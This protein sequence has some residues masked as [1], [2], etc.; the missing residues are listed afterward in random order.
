M[1]KQLTL[2]RIFTYL[3]M[4]VNKGFFRGATATNRA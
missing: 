3:I 1:V 4:Q 2:L